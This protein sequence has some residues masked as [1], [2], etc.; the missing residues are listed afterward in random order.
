M[1]GAGV[2][3]WM[4]S[5]AGFALLAIAVAEIGQ[6]LRDLLDQAFGA[7]MRDQFPS[8][9]LGTGGEEPSVPQPDDVQALRDKGAL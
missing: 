8:T 9:S 1:K 7:Q 5:A 6:R 2:L 3:E 4:A